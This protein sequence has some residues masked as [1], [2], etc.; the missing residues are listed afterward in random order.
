MKT[1]CNKFGCGSGEAMIG[2]AKTE[3][4]EA[5]TRTATEGEAHCPK[6]F[7]GYFKN[8]EQILAQQ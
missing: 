1:R 3:S 5:Q 8:H 2:I 4:L 7:A 6:F